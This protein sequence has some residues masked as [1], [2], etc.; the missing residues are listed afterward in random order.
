MLDVVLDLLHL[1]L[2]RGDLLVHGLGVELGY[3]AD[4]LLDELVDVIHGDLPA[5]EVLVVLHLGEH[6]VKLLFPT[7]LVLLENLVNP[8]LEEYP[9][10]GV[11][12]P[13]VLEFVEADAQLPFQK[14]LGVVGVIDEYVLDTQELRLV[15]HNHAGVR[16]DVALAVGEGVESVYRLVRG[17]IVRQVDD[18]L[19]LVRG[20]V[21]DLLDLDLSLF[22][23][24]DD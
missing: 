13:L 22:L 10:K 15:V 24:L 4:R 20:H 2:D 11:V 12:M 3:L 6:I 7:L 5:E 1:V 23:S 16:G 18:D 14:I 21:L 17:D 19:H 9:L 8:V